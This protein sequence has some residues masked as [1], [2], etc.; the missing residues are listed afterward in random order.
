LIK[1]VQ[2][3][4]IKITQKENIVKKTESRSVNCAVFV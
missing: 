2:T 4:T 3:S 1:T